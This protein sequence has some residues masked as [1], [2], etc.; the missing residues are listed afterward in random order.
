MVD[1]EINQLQSRYLLACAK[2]RFIDPK[3]NYSSDWE[4]DNYGSRFL[5][6]DVI[7]RLN[8]EIRKDRQESWQSALSFTPIIS[9]A[10]GLIGVLIG[11]LALFSKK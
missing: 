8:Q 1:G 6:L 3:I 2:D 4:E 10:T 5:K 11:L 7:Q 9:S